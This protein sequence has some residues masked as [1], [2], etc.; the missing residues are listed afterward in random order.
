VNVIEVATPAAFVTAVFTPPKNVPL[1]PDTGAVNVTV[2][3]GTGLVP[4]SLTT[5][6]SGLENAVLMS[7]DCGVPPTAAIE[8][9]DPGR[10]VNEY[11][12]GTGAPGVVATIE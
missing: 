11:V 6:T 7:V 4:E 8:N 2:A 12:A 5:A 10:F 9:G 3:F 1:W